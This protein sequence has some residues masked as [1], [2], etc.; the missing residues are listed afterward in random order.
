M[1]TSQALLGSLH[2]VRRQSEAATALWIRL[3]LNTSKGVIALRLPPH[4]D[5]NAGKAVH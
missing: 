5:L 4:K 2:G 3:L 1:F